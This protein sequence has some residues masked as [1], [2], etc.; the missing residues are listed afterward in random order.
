MVLT[1]APGLSGAMVAV[2]VVMVVVA[3]GLRSVFSY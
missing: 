1:H 2:V 3:V